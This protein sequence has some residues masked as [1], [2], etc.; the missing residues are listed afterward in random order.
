MR[1]VNLLPLALPIQFAIMLAAIL[2]ST[3]HI[4]SLESFD[5]IYKKSEQSR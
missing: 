5:D 2:G 3:L 1:R 4:F